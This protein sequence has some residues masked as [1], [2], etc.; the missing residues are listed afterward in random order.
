MRGM[1]KQLDF[2][3]KL[4]QISLCITDVAENCDKAAFARLFDHYALLNPFIRRSYA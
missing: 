2:G 1:T 4:A 3:E